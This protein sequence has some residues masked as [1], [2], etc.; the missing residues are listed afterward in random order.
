MQHELLIALLAGLAGMLGWGFA[1][2]FAKKTIDEIGDIV[3]LAWAHVFG[4]FA[5]VLAALFQVTILHKQINIP[6]DLQTFSLLLFFGVLQAAIYLLV[7]KGFGKGQVAVLNPVFASFSGLTALM[8]IL[9][10][11]EIV[12]G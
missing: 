9:I 10:F 12:S 5:L 3:S 11:G 2:F 4:T 6:N 8:S 7:Y 1:D